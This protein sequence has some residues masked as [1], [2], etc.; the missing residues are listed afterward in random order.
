[1]ASVYT[2]S[3]R[4]ENPNP[5]EQTDSWG[6]TENEGRTLVEQAVAGY[7]AKDV[8]ASGTITLSTASGAS[9]EARNAILNFTGTLTSNTNV[10]VPSVSKLYILANNTNGSYTLTV[11]T[12][13]GTGVTVDQGT[14]AVVYCD[15]TN[16]NTALSRSGAGGS[17]ILYP[18][19]GRL[20]LTS[21]IG[22]T[23]SDVTGAATAYLTPTDSDY[24]LIFDGSDF[25]PRQFTETSLIFD[26]TGHVAITNYDVF[27]YWDGSGVKI[28]T[29]P[30][31][32]SATTRGTGAGTTEI[33]FYRGRPVNKNAIILRN[34]STN[35]SSIP[36][37]RA[38][39]RATIRTISVAGQT[40]DSFKKRFV[41]NVY[42]A[43]IRPLH[44]PA[45]TT[46]QWPYNV[47]TW[48]Q[49]N[50]NTANQFEFVQCTSGRPLHAQALNVAFSDGA[51]GRY[52][53]NGIG[54]DSTSIN[55]ATL[56]IGTYA[57]TIPGVFSPVQPMIAV[58]DGFTGAGY[59]KIVWLELG[60][61]ANNNYFQ[62][63]AL[64]DLQGGLTGT[65]VL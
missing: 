18:S 65:T 54:I 12:S 29:G 35:T 28:G 4:L 41:S 11:K 62:A 2:P 44:N 49:A 36:A 24:T 9:D 53:M 58:F 55:S 20:T 42:N 63:H 48:R 33:E 64:S 23:E 7:L 56:T 3:L 30:A 37:R 59:H 8:S 61:A 51:T 34:N 57:V 10:V 19:G 22:T 25:Q 6:V 21:G 17:A 13:G 39:L 26:A 60:N 14:S 46:A 1:M 45:E 32:T 52:L 38:S 50:A 16:V 31:W 5:G 15:G 27:E 43:E 47:A 40:E